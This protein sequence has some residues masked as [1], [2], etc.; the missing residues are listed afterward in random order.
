MTRT[1]PVVSS[2]APGNYITSAA[3][4]SGPKALGDWTTSPPVCTVYQ[5]TVQAVPS[6][7]WTAIT[8]DSESLD[9]DGFHSVVSNTSRL[10]IVIAGTYRIDGLVAFVANSTGV[11][12][13]RVAVNG[14][15]IRSQTNLPTT[16]GSAWSAPCW[17]EVPLN[18]NDY[19]EIQ[20][21]HNSGGALNTNIAVDCNCFAAL[22][23]VSS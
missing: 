21:F 13:A 16:V 23:F 8:Y 5:S 7:T 22:T 12:G 9:T 4:N 18:L 15:A 6:G 2:Q 14:T 11:R 1:I 20:A 17:A 19:V 10:T 3:W